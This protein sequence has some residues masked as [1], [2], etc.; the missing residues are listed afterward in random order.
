V[1]T[2]D[3]DG[4]YVFRERK[5]EIIIHG[6]SNVGP[7]EVEN[8]IDS[9]PDVMESC[10]VGVPDAHFGA[11]L[12]AYIEWEPDADQPDL[13]TLKKYVADNLAKYKVPD[14]W[15][16][17]DKLPKTATGKLDRK[18]LHQRGSEEI[19]KLHK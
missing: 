18:M 8:I 15:K 12:E 17:M 11:I 6:G 9:Y 2:C 5:K 7:H 3:E 4:F 10:V 13:D 14:R 19:K 1:A 16:V